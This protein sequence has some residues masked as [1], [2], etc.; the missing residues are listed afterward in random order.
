M[1]ISKN[2][3]CVAGVMSGTSLDGIDVVIARIQGHGRELQIEKWYGATYSFP[4]ELHSYLKLAASQESIGVAELSQLNVRLAH[5]YAKAVTRT[6]EAHGEPIEH[7]DLVGCHGQTIRHLPDKV[8]VAGKE[9]CSTLQIG[10]PS[11]MAQLL[12][13]PVI[14]DF[15]LAD[16]ARG[17]QGAPLVPY[18]D[19]VIFTHDT[20][21]R[22]CLN[23]G[24]VAN[25]TVLPPNARTD[26]VYGFDTG[27]GNM[28]MDTLCRQCMDLPFDEGGHI[29][30]SGTVNERLLSELLQ[31]P[32]LSATPPKSTGREY[33][34]HTFL[35]RLLDS[36]H[37]M[38]SED[39]IATA[40]ALTA[41]S[42]WQAYKTFIQPTHS[43]DRLILSG[44]GAHN[45]ALLDL[46]GGYF[47]Q[48]EAP[49][50]IETS[51]VYGVGVDSKEALC[52]AV[53]AHESASGIPTNIPSVTGADRPAVL[54]KLCVL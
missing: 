10:D 30:K 40:T 29:A 34:S 33:L 14:G 48:N 20:E 23:V 41:A 47:A 35:Q 37:R 28:I 31:D 15:R 2:R 16:M 9:I 46:L 1:I 39:L 24:G 19:Y 12:G 13:V 50:Q 25:L 43:L 27:P 6:L 52:F 18:F 51:D 45:Q 44:G 7:L 26:Q 49:V 54:G 5:E 21:T 36:S 53:L 38:L 4:E 42:V 3:R 8:M 11:T 32:Y 17:G 22:G